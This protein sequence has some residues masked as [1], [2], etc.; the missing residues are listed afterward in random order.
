MY[1]EFL[2]TQEEMM[3]EEMTQEERKGNMNKSTGCS[4]TQGT[5]SNATCA[6]NRRRV[7]SAEDVA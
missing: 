6:E 5:G 3:Q 1:A 2:V 4:R 7:L